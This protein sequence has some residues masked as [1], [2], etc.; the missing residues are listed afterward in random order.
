MQIEESK[1]ASLLRMHENIRKAQK[2]YQKT[3]PEVMNRYAIDYYKRHKDD[4]EFIRK[5]R[6]RSL[7]N[8]YRKRAKADEI[9]TLVI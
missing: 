2:K 7:S 3:H 6:E 8:Y 4:P 5:R 9:P 1:I